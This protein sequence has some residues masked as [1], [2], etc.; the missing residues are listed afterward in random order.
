MIKENTVIATMP[1]KPQEYTNLGM[2]IA[3]TLMDVI[4]E[5]LQCRKVFA[6]NL[7]NAYKNKESCK[8]IYESDILKNGIT[9]DDLFVDSL[10]TDELLA[11]IY[12]MIERQIVVAENKEVI[13]CSCGKVDMLYDSTNNE[14]LGKL[15]KKEN[16]N[17]VCTVCGTECK[18]Y[19]QD[20][21]LLELNENVDDSVKIVPNFLSKDINHLSKIFRGSKFLVSKNRETGY[22]INYKG[23][24]YNIDIDFLWL[25]YF[26]LFPEENQI[27]IASNHQVYQ[28]YIMNYINKISSDKNLNFIANPYVRV[29]N[30]YYPLEQYEQRSNSIYKKL[31]ILYSL[32]W[33]K[34]ESFWDYSTINYLSNISDTRK[35][36]LYE[37]ILKYENDLMLTTKDLDEYIEE[38]L[39]KGI[40]M[41]RNI[42]DAKKLIREKRGE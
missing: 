37:A 36:N 14:S 33:R 22:K 10:V 38:F 21:L 8:S 1:I 32:K 27:L 17:F 2:Y 25:N 26:K 19:K 24:D 40:N 11:I 3:P 28:M 9:F 16:E 31:L 15:Y 12:E 29:L 35:K 7:L 20:V 30:D 5:K 23:K 42:I 13:R 18:V 34:K 6:M 41:Q 4:G 39:Q